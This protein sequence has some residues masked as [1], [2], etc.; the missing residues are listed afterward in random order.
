VARQHDVDLLVPERLL[1][2]LLDDLVAHVRRDVGIHP[3]RADVERPAHGPPEQRPSND[4]NRLDS[5]EPDAPPA[6]CHACEI[7]GAR[8]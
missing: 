7:T 5:V 3:E 8:K 2:V 4:R 6:L 1:G